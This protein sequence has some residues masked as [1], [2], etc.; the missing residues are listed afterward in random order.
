MFMKA[1]IPCRLLAMIP[2]IVF[3]LFAAEPSEVSADGQLPSVLII[4][5]SISMAYHA[6]VVREL[7]GKAVVKRI[8]GNGE[9][10][11]TGMKKIDEWL[12][13]GKWNVIHFNWGLWDMY[14]WEYAKEDRSPETYAKRLDALV[15]RLEKTGAKLI[16]ATTTPACPAAESTMLKRF[17]T[18]TVITPELEQTYLDAARLVME[19]HKV[20]IND[21]HAL[22]KPVL[23]KHALAP[24]DVHF[25]PSGSQLLGKQVASEILAALHSEASP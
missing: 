8:P 24:D 25:K 16:W 9:Y 2:A 20:R 6:T 18:E 17:K 22:I 4:G 23:Q 14:G 12:G 10:T 1:S 5:D 21:L 13:D 15:T 11:G 3:S 19:R 7:D